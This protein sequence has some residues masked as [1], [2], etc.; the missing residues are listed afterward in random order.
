MADAQYCLSCGTPVVP[1]TITLCPR[2]KGEVDRGAR[3]CKHCSFDL[4]AP[5]HAGLSSTASNDPGK[6][7]TV[8]GWIIA[9]SILT[10]LVIAGISSAAVFYQRAE[11]ERAEKE[12]LQRES[13]QA[14]AQRDIAER[15]KAQAQ[16]DKDEAQKK[17]DE[18]KKT[19]AQQDVLQTY[20]AQVKEQLD[21]T[22]GLYAGQGFKKIEYYADGLSAGQT[23]VFNMSLTG[24]TQYKFVSVCD[25]DCGD[26]DLY[27]NNADGSLVTSD[28]S[29]DDLP[30]VFFN[31]PTSTQVTVTVK[32]FSCANSP[33]VYGIGAYA[34]SM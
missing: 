11:Q 12:R 33:C 8:I 24:R 25:S 17:A 22:T 32:M 1:E 10:I 30:E 34:R 28:V 16:K 19:R 3:Y 6:K 23:K 26:I 9:C 14:K 4:V 7:P 20:L 21:K 13:D 31:V 29:R 27:V 15:D 5:A 18:E 2:C